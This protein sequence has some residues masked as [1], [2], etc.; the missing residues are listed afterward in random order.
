MVM[1]WIVLGLFLLLLAGV[2]RTAVINAR[3]LRRDVQR[4]TERFRSG[5]ERDA[6]QADRQPDRRRRAA[7]GSALRL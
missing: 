1:V 5:L 7:C 6:K 2:T 4:S 3:A